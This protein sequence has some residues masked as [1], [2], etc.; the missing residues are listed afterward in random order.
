M[1]AVVLKE[2]RSLVVEDIPRPVLAG[3]EVL[4]EVKACGICGSDLRYFNGENP[5]AKQTLGYDKPN[6][7]DMILG[8]EFAGVIVD[9]GSPALKP[10]IGERVAAL[11]FKACGIGRY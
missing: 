1:R 7:P 8:H 3:D 6:P 2:P 11:A 5:W 10:R 4:I 9:A